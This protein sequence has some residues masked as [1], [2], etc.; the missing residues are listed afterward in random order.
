MKHYQQAMRWQPSAKPAFALAAALH[1]LGR[2]DEIE[3]IIEPVV[4]AQLAN[5]TSDSDRSALA[6][7]TGQMYTA[8]GLLE[9]AMKHYQQAMRWQPSAKPAIA[10]AAALQSGTHSRQE[11]SLAEP[12]VLD[13]LQRYPNDI[14]LL[15]TMSGLRY[16]QGDLAGVVELSRKVLAIEKHNE[17]ALNNLSSL[18]AEQPE[19]QSE[20]LELIQDAIERYGPKPTLLDTK[21][22]IFFHKGRF[23]DASDL[24]EEATKNPQRDGRIYFHSALVCQQLG[25]R[26]EAK[27]KLVAARA[28]GLQSSVLTPIERDLLS[29]LESSLGAP[30]PQQERLT[31]SK[32]P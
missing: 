18:L 4:E 10:L 26:N 25:E 28:A 16:L 11:F 12:F 24:L 3:S 23:R 32:L 29:K 9:P 31:S 22:M 27:E 14:Q 13:A 1:A 17:L 30:A 5:C 19:H 2:T 6:L 20:A 7:S 8:V 21:A 15:L